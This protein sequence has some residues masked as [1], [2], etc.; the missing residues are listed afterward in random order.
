MNFDLQIKLLKF[1]ALEEAGRLENEISFNTMMA[2]FDGGILLILGLAISL[3]VIFVKR[4]MKEDI[5]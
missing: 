3:A 5:K 1:L 4:E 2:I